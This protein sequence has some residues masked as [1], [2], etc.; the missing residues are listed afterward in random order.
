MSSETQL[1][2]ESKDL[3]IPKD[4]VDCIQARKRF[5]GRKMSYWLMKTRE[6]WYLPQPSQQDG[7]T[8]D[9]QDKQNLFQSIPESVAVWVDTGFQGAAKLHRNTFIPIKRR[10]N[11]PLTEEE[12]NDNRIISSFRVVAEHAICGMKRYNCLQFPYRNK[13]PKLDDSLA[14]LSAGLWNYHL[15]LNT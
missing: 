11:H 12:K 14:L 9:R 10:K 7:M 13:K 8:K 2:E 4:N 3:K 15:S 1:K 5:M 6:F